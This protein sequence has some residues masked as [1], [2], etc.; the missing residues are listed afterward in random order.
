MAFGAEFVFVVSV[1]LGFFDADQRKWRWAQM[2]IYEAQQ[3]GH[4]VKG[5]GT[6]T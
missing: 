3:L 1:L 4:L 6:R 2:P 5:S